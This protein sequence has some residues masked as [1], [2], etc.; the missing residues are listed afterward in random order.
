M[1]LTNDGRQGDPD[2]SEAGQHRPVILKQLLLLCL[3]G[4]SVQFL[5]AYSTEF[6]VNVGGANSG[7]FLKY[8]HPLCQPLFEL[9]NED[10]T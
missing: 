5:R 7:S 6:P 3:R 1:V 4:A 2:S 9:V 8:N 10:G